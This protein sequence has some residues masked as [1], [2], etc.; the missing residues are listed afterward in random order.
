MHLIALNKKMKPSVR[1]EEEK[2]AMRMN[3]PGQIPARAPQLSNKERLLLRRQALKMK[4]RPVLAVGNSCFHL[5][6]CEFFLAIEEFLNDQ[7]S[8]NQLAFFGLI[9]VV[10]DVW[11]SSLLLLVNVA[12]KI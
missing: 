5:F 12:G 3:Q 8:S 7:T 10:A 2:L 6:H 11:N 4:K 1:L 9:F